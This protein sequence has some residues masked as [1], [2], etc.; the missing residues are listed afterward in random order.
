MPRRDSSWS[1]TSVWCVATR[2]VP[3]AVARIRAAASAASHSV[4]AVITRNLSTEAGAP[5]SPMDTPSASTSSMIPGHGAGSS[6]RDP[7]MVNRSMPSG[8]T[9]PSTTS[10]R[11]IAAT[12]RRSSAAPGA[13]KSSSASARSAKRGEAPAT[14]EPSHPAVT[15]S[16]RH[17]S[18]FFATAHASSW[19]ESPHHCR[20]VRASASRYAPMRRGRS[21]ITP[22]MPR[23]VPRIPASPAGPTAACPSVA[24]D[25]PSRQG[26]SHAAPSR[27]Q[28]KVISMGP[29]LGKLPDHRPA[30]FEH[31]CPAIAFRRFAPLVF[32]AP[33]T[34]SAGYS[35][36]R[37]TKIAVPGITAP[38]SGDHWP[39]VT[40]RSSGHSGSMRSS[41]TKPAPTRSRTRS[42]M[43]RWCST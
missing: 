36:S 21:S 25:S 10:S 43:V 28:P 40:S 34:C 9:T 8:H 13:S 39:H 38:R 35:A 6:A 22:P 18:I 37:A 17:D 19:K 11:S 30:A 24:R 2:A 20:D 3:G 23:R 32:G 16:S 26:L 29:M 33:A 27:P 31:G 14:G 5:S 42:P 1:R 7:K 41:R 15:S 12:P 4:A